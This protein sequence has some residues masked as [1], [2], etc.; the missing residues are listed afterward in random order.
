MNKQQPELSSHADGK[1]LDLHSIFYTIQGEGPYRGHPALFIRLAG[2][3]LQCPGCDTEYTQGRNPTPVD[4]IMDK[5]FSQFPIDRQG[6]VVI[7]GGEP[8]RQNILEL[9]HRLIMA[10]IKVQIETN[11]TYGPQL[12]FPSKVDIVCSPK[13]PRVAREMLPRVTAYKYV[14]ENGAVDPKDG[15]PSSILGNPKCAPARPPTM[16]KGPIFVGPMDTGDTLTNKLN[17]E[18]AVKS[19]MVFGYILNLQIHKLVGLP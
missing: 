6:F 14:I 1:V 18:A 2:C 12:G 17:T 11:G 10:G 4:K 13:A 16:Y 19:C 5:V 15:L 9:V 8:F 7:T 3:N